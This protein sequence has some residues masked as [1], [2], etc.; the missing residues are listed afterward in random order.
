MNLASLFAP[1]RIAPTQARKFIENIPSRLGKVREYQFRNDNP[2]FHDVPPVSNAPK[3]VKQDV[4]SVAY[5]TTGIPQTMEDFDK[6]N[7]HI[8]SD[9]TAGYTSY[10]PRY[11]WYGSELFDG[12]KYAT[13]ST[14]VHERTHWLMHPQKA[15]EIRALKS[16][17]EYEPNQL[18]LDR[19]TDEFLI[20]LF[21]DV[22]E[23]KSN[24]RDNRIINYQCGM[25]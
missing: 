15:M 17:P 21:N 13:P 4:L 20:H 25:I 11:I 6:A 18:D 23:C 14:R 19:Y 24:Q 5:K 10:N 9:G 7:R 22:A 2:A 16:H 3:N 12:V 8:M 1:K